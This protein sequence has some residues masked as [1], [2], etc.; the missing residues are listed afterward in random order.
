MWHVTWE[1][2]RNRHV[3]QEVVISL[4][5]IILDTTPLNQDLEDK[6]FWSYNN[7]GLFSVSLGYKVLKNSFAADNF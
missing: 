7:N 3:R 2:R 5:N 1:A 4:M 6:W